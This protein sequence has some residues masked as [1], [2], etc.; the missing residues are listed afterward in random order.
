[1]TKK[2]LA[3]GI[4]FGC[5]SF[6]TLSTGE[7]YKYPQHLKKL[8]KDI[9]RTS[10]KLRSNNAYGHKGTLRKKLKKLRDTFAELTIKFIETL[11]SKVI[12]RF[13]FFFVEDINKERLLRSGTVKTV[14]KM[15]WRKFIDR[16]HQ[17]C[18]RRGKV[19]VMVPAANT[20][21][22]CSDCGF[23]K[24]DLK[25]SDR[26]YLCDSCGLQID[27]DLNACR[28]VVIKGTEILNAQTKTKTRSKC[29][30]RREH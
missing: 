22:T 17:E 24:L 8:R 16:L 30:S 29:A 12:S 18:E 1:M 27:R 15:P 9:A 3:V 5:T 7:V 10:G 14:A 23:L 28:N 19:F 13:H 2:A 21:R 11:V 20:S 26:T 25:L 4:D 6:V